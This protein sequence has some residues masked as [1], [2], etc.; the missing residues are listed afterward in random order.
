MQ[1]HSEEEGG[2][3][4]FAPSQEHLQEAQQMIDSLL[5]DKK[6]KELEFGAVYSGKVVELLGNGVLIQLDPTL[7]PMMLHNSQLSSRK[8]IYNT[9]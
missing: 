6:V 5:E 7:E 9:F 3:L 2:W 4:L 1:V 8:V